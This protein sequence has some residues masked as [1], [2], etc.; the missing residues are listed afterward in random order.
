MHDPSEEIVSEALYEAKLASIPIPASIISTLSD[1]GVWHEGHLRNLKHNKWRVSTTDSNK[2]PNSTKTIEFDI[3][4]D[5][6]SVRLSSPAHRHDL[7]TKKIFCVEILDNSASHRRSM[8]ATS[9]YKHALYF[10]WLIR[11]RNSLPISRFSDLT[12]AHYEAF[13]EDFSH[14][15]VLSALPIEDRLDVLMDDPDFQLPL[16]S[17]GQKQYLNASALADILGI[18]SSSLGRSKNFR[19]ALEKRAPIF[20]ARLDFNLSVCDLFFRKPG[21]KL[22]E[23]RKDDSLHRK[24]TVWQT[25]DILSG[26]NRLAHD[27]LQFRMSPTSYG[28]GVKRS[29]PEK[30]TTSLLPHDF[31]RLLQASA[32]W[33]LNNAEYILDA[34]DARAGIPQGSD[35]ECNERVLAL[36]TLID[37]RKPPGLQPLGLSPRTGAAMNQGRLDLASAVK[38]L[39]VALAIIIGGFSARRRTEVK[40]LTPDC[41]ELRG[42]LP[43]LNIYIEKTLQ[44][45]DGIP[46]TEIVVHAISILKRLSRSAREASSEPNIFQ[47]L[48]LLPDGATLRCS[49]D[50]WRHL[51]EFV[52]YVNLEPPAGAGIWR[53]NYHMFRKGFAITYYH[54]NLWGSFDALNRMLRHLTDT[55]TRIY[56]DDADMGRLAWLNSEVARLSKLDVKNLAPSQQAYLE[57][58]RE[59]LSERKLRGEEWN[60][61]RQEFFVSKMMATFDVI[62]RPIGKG[63]ALMLDQ[64]RE[65]E[66]QAYAR[67]HVAAPRSNSEAGPRND[68]LRQVRK[69][70]ADHFME[71]IPGNF[72]FCLFRRG[73]REHAPL[74]NCL[75]SRAACRRP[76]SSTTPEE[77]D[78]LPDFAFSGLYPCIGCALYA[79]FDADQK[80]LEYTTDHLISAPARAATPALAQSAQEYVDGLLSLIDEARRAV[81]GKKRHNN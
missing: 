15:D 56:T 39:F 55:M 24:A 29:V 30:R 27:S 9:L 59:A 40:G 7:L 32:E 54:G 79:G 18:S 67:I 58:A 2:Y 62:E 26:T 41:I 16:T 64:L 61:V 36:Q 45:V 11:W 14:S 49:T 50:F 3:F 37:K 70:A 60:E 80:V 74:A 69:A 51:L 71:P 47:F 22:R 1:D 20:L 78:D 72:G 35:R 46:T 65:Y 76:W 53:L 68:V 25:L 17:H 13:K 12:P 38:Y 52:T 73:Y 66:T 57:N 63:A 23:N 77:R 19:V 43:Y 10:D 34:I 6:P 42:N 4:V 21:N 28:V 31:A 44:D 5:F 81:D 8:G 75:K 48:R 33:V